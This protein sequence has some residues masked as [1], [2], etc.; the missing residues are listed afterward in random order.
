MIDADPVVR[1]ALTLWPEWAGA[2]T[3]GTTWPD[4]LAPKQVENRG[5]RPGYTTRQARGP[6]AT[7]RARTLHALPEG[8]RLAIHAGKHLNGRPRAL[9]GHWAIRD[10]YT[11]F[12]R[13]NPD[14]SC[15][16]LFDG[17]EADLR[18]CPRSSIVAVVTIDGYDQEQRTGWDVPDA[19]HWRFR[20]VQ[21][22]AE[23][24]PCRGAQGLWALP[25]E[26]RE[27]LRVAL[28]AS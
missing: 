18:A 16:P 15:W 5:W 4:D 21:V 2:I 9:S 19:W 1:L 27:R 11:A 13:A 20:D 14:P 24:I 25:W 26:V 17:W 7:D 28:G 3:H 8:S 12:T 23:P 10:V 6:T 22:L